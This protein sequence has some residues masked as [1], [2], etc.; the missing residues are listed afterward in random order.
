[1]VGGEAS[2]CVSFWPIAPPVGSHFSSKLLQRYS[3][4]C[5]G[6]ICP[7]K[8][9]FL[10]LRTRLASCL[11]VVHVETTPRDK[12]LVSVSK[13]NSTKNV[14]G[15]PEGRTFTSDKNG[16]HGPDGEVGGGRMEPSLSV[17]PGLKWSLR[18]KSAEKRNPRVECVFCFLCR[19][20][21]GRLL[22]LIGSSAVLTDIG[23]NHK[24]HNS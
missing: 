11:T 9:D 15:R 2:C 21:V 5:D 19:P 22:Y 17:I 12:Y 13:Q 4:P 3:S 1:M 14:D 23:I 18:L 24:L 8:E 20:L 6:S 10:L 16:G 7:E